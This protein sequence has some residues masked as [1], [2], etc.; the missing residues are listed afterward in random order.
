VADEGAMLIQRG[1]EGPREWPIEDEI[2]IGRDPGCDIH[3]AD[4][5]VSRKHALVARAADGYVIRDFGS[6]NGLWVNGTPVDGE[7]SLSDGDELSIAARFK[8][9]FVDADAT[10]PLVFEQRGLRVDAD[11]MTVFMN[12]A[13]MD[14]PLSGPQYELLV[15]LYNARGSVVSRDEI[16]RSVWPDADPGGVSEDALDALVR[17]LRLRM[18][19]IDADHQYIITVRGYGFRM[20][21][22]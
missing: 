20:D 2:V 4:R 18:G 13:P 6:K 19:A 9:F 21:M 7:M 17:R 12:G 16:V 3:L 22:P 1:G 14:P 10:A 8:L 15:L 5:Q 11:T